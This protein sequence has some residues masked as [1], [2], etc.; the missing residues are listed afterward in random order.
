MNSYFTDRYIIC[1][2][3]PGYFTAIWKASEKNPQLLSLSFVAYRIISYH[4]FS[5]K[6]IISVD[7][8]K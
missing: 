2:Y 5:R 4:I 3:I 8:W 7:I 6:I 1:L